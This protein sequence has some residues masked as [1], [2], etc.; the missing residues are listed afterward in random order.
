MCNGINTPIALHSVTN[1]LQFN[2]IR[3]KRY[4][5]KAIKIKGVLKMR[6]GKMK[7]HF[8]DI[9]TVSGKKEATVFLDNFDRFRRSFVIFGKNHPEDS[10]LLKILK[11][12]S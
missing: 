5:Y 11:I 2:K 3:Y 7:D 9:Y 1:D 12:Y 10:F 6:D 4:K 8:K